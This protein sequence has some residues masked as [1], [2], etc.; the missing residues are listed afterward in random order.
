MNEA[1]EQMDTT[2]DKYSQSGQSQL[3]FLE[4]A[5]Q[6][7]RVQRQRKRDPVTNL[8]KGFKCLLYKNKIRKARENNVLLL[9]TARQHSGTSCS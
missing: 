1:M 7:L 4:S 9:F 8:S 5:S 2:Q 3:T 6:E